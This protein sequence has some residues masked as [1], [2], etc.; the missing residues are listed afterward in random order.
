MRHSNG[1]PQ[2]EQ[3]FFDLPGIS[4]PFYIIPRMTRATAAAVLAGCL[5]IA[6]ARA[7]PSLPPT[8]SDFRTAIERAKDELY[9]KLVY[10]RVILEEYREGSRTRHEASGS[11]VI[12]SSDGY[13]ATN[14]HVVENALTVRC[15]L[16]DGRQ[17]DAEVV[18]RD[19]TT[20]LALLRL[21]LTPS[22]GPLPFA[23]FGD[24]D[25]LQA[26]DFVTAMGC[27]FGL[28]HS[29]SFGVVSNPARYLGG[30]EEYNWIQTDAS[31]NPGN[32]GGPLVDIEGRIVG[33]NTLAFAKFLAEG[34]GFAIPSKVAA[35]VLERLKR[36]GRID[37]SWLGISLQALQDFDSDTDVPGDTGVLVGSVAPD[38]PAHEAGLRE[39]DLLLTAGG[40]A[41]KGV[42]TVDLAGLRRLLAS[43][44]A[45][46]PV[47]AELRRGGAALALTLTPR[48]KPQ[49]EEKNLDCPEW[50]LTLREIDRF[51]DAVTHYFRPKG[52]Y[53]LGTKPDGNAARSGLE[54]RDI[55]LRI[56]GREI[57]GLPDARQA[58]EAALKRQA[59]RR[60]LL[61]EVLREGLP[62]E[63]ALDFNRT[64][65]T[66]EAER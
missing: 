30:D 29:I 24:S 47:K 51:E 3:A 64:R 28:A 27:P 10:I 48:P 34:L 25:K 46:K 63:V 65:E 23:K 35:E 21:R 18:G 1:A 20:D 5:W 41:L 42:R 22:D 62:V 61:L 7:E 56:D 60:Q 2:R 15:L 52:V 43:L 33:V 9:P 40:R 45:D 14:A 39:G 44:P 17:R 8:A 16:N 54:A 58:Y 31:I 59:G 36:H 4:S 32:S 6:P 19:R 11:G 66:Y 50:M 26:G 13:V 37:R 38:S 57:E 49:L 12:V 53:V 55:V